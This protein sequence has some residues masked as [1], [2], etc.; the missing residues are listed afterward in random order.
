M[1]NITIIGTSHVAK[2]SMREVKRA[3][4]ED[5]PDILALELDKGRLSAL[6][7]EGTKKGSAPIS[8]I[9]F[10]GWLFL[11]F[12]SWLQNKIGKELG[13]MPGAEM[14]LAIKL[15]SERKIKVALIDRDIRLTLKSFSRSIGWKEKWRFINDLVRGLLF[16]K[17]EM[18]KM[19]FEGIDVSKVPADELIEKLILQV[20]E[21]YPGTYSSLIEER[22]QIMTTNILNLVRQAPDKKILVIVGAGHK[23]AIEEEL[24]HISSMEMAVAS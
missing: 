24:D 8:Q 5:K 13:V 2:Q 4:I 23:V 21:R 1:E 15:A 6:M 10:K 20:K 22:N 7:Q 3:I 17:R 11:V 14:K 12:G 9:G 18:K 19:G 16:G